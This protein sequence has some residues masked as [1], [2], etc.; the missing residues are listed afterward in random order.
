VRDQHASFFRQLTGVRDQH[1][2]FFHQL[3]GG[4]DQRAFFVFYSELLTWNLIR[5]FPL[6]PIPHSLFP[7]FTN[8]NKKVVRPCLKIVQF[9]WHF[10]TPDTGHLSYRPGRE[11]TYYA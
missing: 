7:F 10:V 2:S 5:F 11:K 9:S 3:M 6:H 4:R 1:T 8:K